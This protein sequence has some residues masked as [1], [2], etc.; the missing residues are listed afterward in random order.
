MSPYYSTRHTSRRPLVRNSSSS[1]YHEQLQTQRYKE[2]CCCL[3]PPA[4]VRLYIEASISKLSINEYTSCRAIDTA[5]GLD[6][7]A[8]AVLGGRRRWP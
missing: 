1:S 7:E 3:V 2:Q 5:F 4:G 6:G 8:G